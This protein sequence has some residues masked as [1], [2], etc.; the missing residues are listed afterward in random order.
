MGVTKRDP[1]MLASVTWLSSTAVMMSSAP[2]II[3]MSRLG[4][5]DKE[6]SVWFQKSIT[7]NTESFR[8]QCLLVSQH[9]LSGY[10]NGLERAPRKKRLRARFTLKYCILGRIRSE[11]T[12]WVNYF[13]NETRQFCRTES[14]LWT[15]WPCYGTMKNFLRSAEMTL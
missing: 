7:C 12:G 14:C 11:L 15:N 1:R 2:V 13:L 10:L 4:C 8:G 9:C 5:A 3:A 6:K